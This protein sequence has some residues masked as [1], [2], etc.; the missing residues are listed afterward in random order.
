MERS[1][2]Q[3]GEPD[4]ARKHALRSLRSTQ[5]PTNE[6]ETKALRQFVDGTR[7]RLKSPRWVRISY[8]NGPAGLSVT[9]A[10]GKRLPR[11]EGHRA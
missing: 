6:S 9:P 1:V 7:A 2:L 4:P 11:V 8:R 10:C 3:N 5:E